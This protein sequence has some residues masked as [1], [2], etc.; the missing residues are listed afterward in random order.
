[1]ARPVGVLA[2]AIACLGAVAPA[3]A[4]SSQGDD[5]VT[6]T[7]LE[8]GATPTIDGILDEPV[9]STADAMDGFIQ[10]EPD[11]GVAA[12]ERTE[13]RLAYDDAGLYVAVMAFD[14][15]PDRIVARILQRDRIFEADPFGQGAL[16]PAGDDAVAI[17]LDPFHDHRGGVVFGTN[18]NGA[19]FEAI[20]SD[21]G[22]SI[23][24]DW[25]GVWEVAATRGPLGWSAE[26]AIPWR[27]LRYPDAAEVEDWGINVLRIIR[28][29]SEETLWRST[30]REGGGLLRV[31]R[32]GHL[33]GLRDLPRPGLNLEAKPFVLGGRR[34]ELD[35]FGSI[36]SAG[37]LSTGVDIK[38]EVRPGLLLDLTVN[39]DFAQ[40]EVDDAQV[41]L[42]RFDL[43]FP[44][45]RDFF[46][47]NAGVFDFGIPGNPFE[48][49]A[50]QMFF[51]RRIGISEDGEI[52]ILAGAR[53]TGRTGGQT[54]G[55]LNVV[56]GEGHGIGRESFSVARLK[57]DVGESN[58]LGAM[59][60]DRRGHDPANTTAGIDGQFV[61]KDAWVWDFYGARSRTEGG[62]G[63][64]SYS[65]RYNYPGDAWGS[66]FNHYGVTE[67][68]EAD[69]GFITRTDFRRTELYGGPT[70]R[71]DVLG[72]RQIQ[73]FGGGMYASTI[74]DNRLQDWS[75]GFFLNPVWES[76]EN[77]GLFANAAETVLDE[78][79]DHVGWFGG[80][81]SA[82]VVSV[83]TNGMISRFYGGSL[84]SVGGTLT[85]APS[86]QVSVSAGL[87]RN[88]VDVPGGAFTADIATL[89]FGYSF[90]TRAFLNALVQYNSLEDDFSANVRFQLIHR[91]GSDLF[92]VLTENRG[93]DD[94]TWGLSDRG[95]VAKLTYLIRP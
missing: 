77:L 12:S 21:E 88:A 32:A 86:P 46:L 4:Q 66:F 69:A 19:E 20:V 1:M 43:F 44:E 49:P 16:I 93:V 14:A 68:A 48:P 34:Q 7:R 53:L 26:F 13:V 10:R 18:P 22:S 70:W 36:V 92:V 25:R 41:N 45:K 3:S 84:V 50:Y 42:T 56:T 17:L 61:L 63:G 27:T 5:R 52:P 60:V 65:A 59:V 67:G 51:S 62:E 2:T 81:S 30:E 79:F 9:W 40:V 83:S 58:Y 35:D 71:P 15:D 94:R 87:T 8:S 47:E 91:P 85:A 89:R 57:R 23:N 73:L 78:G 31:S 90:S 76:S 38:T 37:D 28:R 80:S 64:T 29:R 54:I 82:R 24:V 33:D 6:A 74:S 11:E 55:L 72:L 39:T 75:A 95:L